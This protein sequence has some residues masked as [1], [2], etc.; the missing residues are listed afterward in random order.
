MTRIAFLG[1]PETAVPTLTALGDQVVLVVTRPDRRSGRARRT[2]P[3]PVKL[4]AIG[5]GIEVQQPQR[6]G[7]IA[8]VLERAEVDV[9]VVVAY[10]VLIPEST[11]TLVPHGFL[12]VHFSLLP[13]W[14]GAAPIERSILAGD[15]KTGVTI[16]Q[17]D[18][19]LDTGPIVAQRE[20]TID[21][22]DDAALVGGR[23]ADVG[24]KLLVE[25]LPAYIAGALQPRPQ[26]TE[27]VTY[28]KSVDASEM[29]IDV[30]SQADLID[31]QVRA[32]AGRGG[33][34]AIHGGERIKIWR[35]GRTEQTDLHEGELAIHGGRV[36]LGTGKGSLELI[37]VQPANRKR[38]DAAAWARGH[39]LGR[40]S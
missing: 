26:P 24:A 31:R 27:G 11:L 40:L 20:I 4:A 22:G 33:A 8:E 19:G 21:A 3:S 13:R 15:Q 38:M 36:L 18:A 17:L 1:T 23:L 25:I 35:T 37:E 2:V 39:G 12:N 29:R 6:G 5:Q 30:S 32:L 7:D 34:W 9:A 16:M 14:R 10:G 28:A